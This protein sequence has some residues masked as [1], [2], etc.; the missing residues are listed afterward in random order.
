MEARHNSDGSPP[1]TVPSEAPGGM[2]GRADP[3]QE[4]A[5]RS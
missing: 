2:G 1:V 3:P 5:G 4:R